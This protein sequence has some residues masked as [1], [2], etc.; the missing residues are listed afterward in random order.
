MFHMRYNLAIQYMAE[1]LDLSFETA[2]RLL[3]GLVAER[4]I[5]Y[6]VLDSLQEMVRRKEV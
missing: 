5:S 2:T 3:E 4:V 6:Q 1:Q